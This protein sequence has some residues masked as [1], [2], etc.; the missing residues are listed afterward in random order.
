MNAAVEKELNE[1]FLGN[2]ITQP[3]FMKAQRL[4]S[5]NA[6]YLLKVT[7]ITY[8]G[9]TIHLVPADAPAPHVDSELE[10]YDNMIANQ[11]NGVTAERAAEAMIE[12]VQSLVDLE[13]TLAPMPTNNSHQQQQA[14][15]RSDPVAAPRKKRVISRDD[16]AGSHDDKDTVSRLICCAL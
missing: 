7:S 16:D 2:T 13:L 14:D 4:S 6:I 10:S 3:R 1:H 8:K 9:T 11:T 15:V 12:A 5:S